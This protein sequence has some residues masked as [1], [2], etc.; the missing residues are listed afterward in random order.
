MC[1]T[2]FSAGK[3]KLNKLG[4]PDRLFRIFTTEALEGTY[5]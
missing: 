3:K 2:L 5:L 1:L 4:R